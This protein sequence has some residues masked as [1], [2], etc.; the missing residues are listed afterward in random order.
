MSVITTLIGAA[1]LGWILVLLLSSVRLTQA[2]TDDERAAA[3]RGMVMSLVAGAVIA[4]GP[5]IVKWIVDFHRGDAPDGKTYYYTGRLEDTDGDG[6]YGDESNIL[7]YDVGNMAYRFIQ[8]A[9]LGGA[10]LAVLGLMWNAIKLQTT[11]SASRGTPLV[12]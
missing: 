9:I 6:D 5:S 12:A 2:H 11:S 1:I 7:P 10:I 4:I 3:Q 8:L